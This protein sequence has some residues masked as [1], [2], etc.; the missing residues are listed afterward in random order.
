MQYI[1]DH[2]QIFRLDLVEHHVLAY[3][4]TAQLVMDFW[5]RLALQRIVGEP[6]KAA[7]DHFQIIHSLLPTPPLLGI[8]TDLHQARVCLPGEAEF[9]HQ[10]ASRSRSSMSWS[11]AYSA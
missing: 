11:C 10:P 9:R 5:A 8:K 7:I 3:G 6:L 2:N 4:I 1:D